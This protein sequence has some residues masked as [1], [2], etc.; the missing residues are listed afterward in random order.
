MSLKVVARAF[1][2]Q[3]AVSRAPDL[4]QR[5]R[6]QESPPHRG[7]PPLPYGLCH[8]S[9]RHCRPGTG[10]PIPLAADWLRNLLLALPARAVDRPRRTAGG[11]DHPFADSEIPAPPIERTRTSGVHELWIRPARPTAAPMPRVRTPPSRFLLCRQTP[12]PFRELTQKT[13]HRRSRRR[14]TAREVHHA[15][16]ENASTSPPLFPPN[17]RPGNRTRPQPPPRVAA[18]LRPYFPPSLRPSPSPPFPPRPQMP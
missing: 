9:G 12:A 11:L 4:Q 15:R 6:A 5:A 18:S 8:R 10:A 16:A 17:V 1:A 3:A 13:M 7:S 14:Y 2:I